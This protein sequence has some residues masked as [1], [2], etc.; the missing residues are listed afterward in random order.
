VDVSDAAGTMLSE[1]GVQR[2]TTGSVHDA[3]G[4]AEDGMVAA[5]ALPLGG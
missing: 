5:L 1:Q 4:G 3:G 2:D